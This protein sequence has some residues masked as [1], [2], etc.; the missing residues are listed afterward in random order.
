M[1]DRELHELCNVRTQLSHPSD[2]RRQQGNTA[3][4]IL[5]HIAHDY[6]CLS[7]FEVL[8]CTVL[9]VYIPPC[10]LQHAHEQVRLRP[11]LFESVSTKF[12]PRILSY[13]V[14]E[15][16]STFVLNI[17]PSFNRQCSCVQ[18]YKLL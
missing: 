15:R 3:P 12:L 9:E 4:W 8:L 5:V 13:F 7:K 6:Q 17:R 1:A 18:T 10:V 14:C 16:T 11:Y 2:T